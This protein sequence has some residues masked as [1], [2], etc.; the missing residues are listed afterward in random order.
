MERPLEQAVISGVPATLTLKAGD[1][2]N[3]A[4]VASVTPTGASLSY[5]VTSGNGT[6][7]ST[8][9]LTVDSNA[10]N[11]DEI[12]VTVSAP[13]VEHV[14]LA[15][16][17]VTCTV[18]VSDEDL[19]SVTLDFMSQNYSNGDAF[20]SLTVTPVTA[21][22]AK[23]SAS[24]APAF[25]TASPTGIRVYGGG[26]MTVSSAQVIK[27]IEITGKAKNTANT[28]SV[29]VGSIS[30]NSDATVYTWTGSASSVVVTVD[31]STGNYGFQNI[32][33]YYAEGGTVEP[34]TLSSIAVS[35]QKTS[36][37]QG[38]A[39]SFGG[40]VTATYSDASTKDVTGSA[41]FSGYDMSTISDEQTVTVSYTEESVTKT[42]TYTIKVKDPN[43]GTDFSEV[44]TTD[45]NVTV[46]GG[47]SASVIINNTSYNAYKYEGR[48][49]KTIQSA[50]ITVPEGTKKIHLFIGAWNN[51]TASVTVEG[52]TI[53]EASLTADS[54]ISSNSPFTLA[55][56][57]T[58]DFYKVI[59]LDENATSVTVTP[60]GE[61]ILIWGVNA[62]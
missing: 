48:T 30:A 4:N 44:Y 20:T 55:A 6:I 49:G 36:F 24:T 22:A 42:T 43:A 10:P 54:G 59:T 17:P 47:T 56:T 18:T 14:C 7:T 25:Y 3:F 45:E 26:T 46:T 58:S 62:D 31:S 53:D 13:A 27:K 57:S 37:N 50:T 15:A 40:T 5:E 11:N 38:D 41:T 16:T 2:Y 21:T 52:G 29:T 32:V 8:G 12:V 1:T 60:S 9:V 61:R 33:V 19:K 39:F 23:G 34:V 28:L 51:G 35:G